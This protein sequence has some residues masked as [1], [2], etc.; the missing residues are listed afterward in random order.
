MLEEKILNSRVVEQKPE[1]AALNLKQVI[2][3]FLPDKVGGEC[4]AR[5]DGI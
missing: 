1:E 4:E 2:F 3:T 5:S